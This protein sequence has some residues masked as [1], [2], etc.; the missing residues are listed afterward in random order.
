[1]TRAGATVCALLFVAGCRILLALPETVEA[2]RAGA[3][4]LLQVQLAVSLLAPPESVLLGIVIAAAALLGVGL[5]TGDRS[6]RAIWPFALCLLAL[7][8]VGLPGADLAGAL[9][10]RGAVG[11][12]AAGI[13]ALSALL[14]WVVILLSA[15]AAVGLVWLVVGRTHKSSTDAAG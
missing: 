11:L 2:W 6:L 9:M 12:S 14:I 8:L 1:M 10:T 7:D 15:G 13:D 5:L 3:T 4:S